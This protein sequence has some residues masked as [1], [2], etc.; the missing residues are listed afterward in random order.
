MMAEVDILKQLNHKNIVKFIEVFQIIDRK[1]ICIVTDCIEGGKT[2]RNLMIDIEK[3]NFTEKDAY[4]VFSQIV[5]GMRHAYKKKIIHR[6]LKPEN[7]LIDKK[8]QILITG[9]GSSI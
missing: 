5:F 4:K 9:F 6:N 8:G 2:L 3:V 7:I 1:I